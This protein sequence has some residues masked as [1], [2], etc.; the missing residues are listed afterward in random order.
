MSL[1]GIPQAP[2]WRIRCLLRRDGTFLGGLEGFWDV[3]IA[4]CKWDGVLEKEISILS[5][6]IW[7]KTSQLKQ[8][9][10]LCTNISPKYSVHWRPLLSPTGAALMS[11]VCKLYLNTHLAYVHSHWRRISPAK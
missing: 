2:G 6:M 7:I 5:Q 3:S 10:P 11:S 1:K 9:S 4:G 8:G